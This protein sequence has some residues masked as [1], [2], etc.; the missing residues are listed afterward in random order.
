LEEAFTAAV[1]ADVLEPK[2]AEKVAWYTAD[3]YAGKAAVTR[4]AFGQGKVIYLG[5]M[6]DAAYYAAVARWLSAMAGVT[7][8]LE[9]PAGVEVSERWSEQGRLLFLLNHTDVTQ[10]V[11]VGSGFQDL[12][13]GEAT[14][15]GEIC[16]PA[17]D[18]RI[19]LERQ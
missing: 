1:W 4:N 12:L 14:V 19:L 17:K 2:G 3:Y 6:G 5:A 8:L 13:Q 11:D 18:V 10:S 7:P 15:S 16:L 9:T